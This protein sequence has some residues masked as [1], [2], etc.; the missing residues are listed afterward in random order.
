LENLRRYG[1]SAVLVQNAGTCFSSSP[2]LSLNASRV[3]QE[4]IKAN[5]AY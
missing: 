3:G 2:S 4:V 1:A 5:A